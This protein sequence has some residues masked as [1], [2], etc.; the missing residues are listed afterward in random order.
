MYTIIAIVT[1]IITIV[2]LT[3]KKEEETMKELTKLIVEDAVESGEYNIGSAE[4][5]GWNYIT[6]QISAI[7]KYMKKNHI[8]NLGIFCD[9]NEN[10]ILA[11]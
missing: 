9:D 11:K 4:Q 10:W 5:F 8:D 3:K 2:A 7:Q 1:I 6:K